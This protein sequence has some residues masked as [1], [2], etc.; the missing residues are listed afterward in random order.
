MYI[1]CLVMLRQFSAADT[2]T[3]Q[4]STAVISC[5]ATYRLVRLICTG[6][7]LPAIGLPQGSELAMD[8]AFDFWDKLAAHV[9]QF[10]ILA[11]SIK[12]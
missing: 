7:L 9:G 1:A 10:I 8:A 5:L 2:S 11:A 3:A 4:L 12:Y 6:V